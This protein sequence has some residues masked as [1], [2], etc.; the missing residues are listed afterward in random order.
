MKTLKKVGALVLAVTLAGTCALPAG[1]AADEERFLYDDIDISWID[2]TKPM[3]AF[4]FDDGPVG[5][6]ASSSAQAIQD[7]LTAAGAHATFFYIGSQINNADKEKEVTQ[8]VERG[9]EV[10]NHSWGW[11]GMAGMTAEEV[12][13]SI[14]DTDAKLTELTG[15]TNFLF[16]APNLSTS[17]TMFDTIKKPFLHCAVDS[18]D[19]QSGKTKEEIIANVQR[20]KD[21][22]VILMHETQ[23]ATAEAVPE[24]LK[25][26]ADKG[27]QVVSVSELY[28]A[29]NIAL[30]VGALNQSAPPNQRT[31]PEQPSE[32]PSPWA[33]ADVAAAIDAGLVPTALQEKYSAEITRAEFCALAVALYEGYKQQDITE[34]A[35]FSDTDD[36][37]VQKMA[38][39]GVVTGSDGA[40]NPDET[41][42]RQMAA[43]LIA[44]LFRSFGFELSAVETTFGDK[45][46]IA[47]WAVAA[48]SQM[49]AAGIITGNSAGNFD[50]RGKFT[51]QSGIVQMLKVWKYLNN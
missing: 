44:N 9:F 5:T 34:R 47:S 14:A 39:L 46:K 49:Q 32:Q 17:K 38:G 31:T 3:V 36:I 2:P 6:G 35:A 11:S 37:N 23:K 28:A 13:K 51:R 22:D 50:P 24:L 10:A 20:A 26:F 16:R 40:F 29:S 43:T 8:A 33:A 21:G 4:T 15:F 19:W 18:Q 45:D 1:F 41:F 42:N 48:V 12:A 27:W 25:F 7:A 30:K